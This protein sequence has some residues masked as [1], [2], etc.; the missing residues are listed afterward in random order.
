MDW[1]SFLLGVLFCAPLLAFVWVE[2]DFRGYM[3]AIDD[4]CRVIRVYDL[5]THDGELHDSLMELG[6]GTE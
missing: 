1:I 4:V 6:G 3:S 2:A 5:K